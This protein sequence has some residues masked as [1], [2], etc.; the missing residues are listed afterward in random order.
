MTGTILIQLLA[1]QQRS[2]CSPRTQ[3]PLRNGCNAQKA[4]AQ[5]ASLTDRAS[6]E[7]ETRAL[8]THAGGRARAGAQARGGARDKGYTAYGLTC[9]CYV[10]SAII[11]LP[12]P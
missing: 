2:S 1:H 7:P 12:L 4:T 3:T 6:T 9:S 11:L 5:L 8:S 10:A